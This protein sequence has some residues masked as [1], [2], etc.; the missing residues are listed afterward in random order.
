MIPAI[1]LNHMKAGPAMQTLTASARKKSHNATTKPIWLASDGSI[2]RMII[3]MTC[4]VGR[5]YFIQTK[6]T[7]SGPMLDSRIPHP[8]A[9]DS[10]RSLYNSK[11]IIF[12]SISDASN[13]LIGYSIDET[14]SSVY[15]SIE[16]SSQARELVGYITGHYR[17]ARNEKTQSGN[18]KPISSCVAGKAWLIYLHT[19]LESIGD[20]A[21]SE[22][23][24][25]YLP[26]A[27]MR[28]SDEPPTPL[29][30]RNPNGS[31]ATDRTSNRPSP[32]TTSLNAKKQDLMADNANATKEIQDKYKEEREYRKRDRFIQLR[33]DVEE[34]TQKLESAREALKME[35]EGGA[36]YTRVRRRKRLAKGTMKIVEDEYKKLKKELKYES[37]S[38]SSEDDDE[39]D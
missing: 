16:T 9:W 18:H 5:P 14:I 10:M 21:L 36:D 26:E 20:S 2:Y 13:A 8:E 22:C 34:A 7:F 23:T 29:Q 31:T 33:N 11:D 1:I 24:Y 28:A 38:D 3:V 17:S 32:S 15:D 39:E 30:R 35:V 19:R 37:P 25:P 6:G 27:A 4:E 12:D